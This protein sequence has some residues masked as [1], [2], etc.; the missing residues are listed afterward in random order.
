MRRVLAE[1]A[2]ESDLDRSVPNRCSE[3]ARR[4]TA[5]WRATRVA[6]HWSNRRSA[7]D[8]HSAVCVIEFLHRTFPGPCSP[9]SKR[10]L[11]AA[12]YVSHRRG[13]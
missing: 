4:D 3:C 10:A 6:E 2:N 1:R 8:P 7:A 11:R 9:N 13:C 5:C 12:M